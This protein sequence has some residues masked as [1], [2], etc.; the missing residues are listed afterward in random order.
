MQKAS[1]IVALFAICGAAPAR[2]CDVIESYVARLGAA[3]HFNSAGQRLTN[4]AAIIRQDRANFHA[5]GLRDAE[6]QGDAYF[7]SKENRAILERM[8]AGGH[9]AP[10]VIA[11]VVNGT[12][13]VEVSVCRGPMGDV[14][15]LLLLP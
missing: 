15:D 7:A 13:R 11:E 14:V 4:A 3:D 2:A 6:D 1:M 12:P 10:R 9:S 5:F 8:L